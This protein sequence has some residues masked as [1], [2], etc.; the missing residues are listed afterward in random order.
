[1]ESQDE[2]KK[3]YSPPTLTKLTTEQARQFVADRNNCSE[4]EA[5]DSLK[6][7]RKHPPFDVTEQKRKRSA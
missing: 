5:T 1:M 6:S 7:L 2:K 3:P 4:E